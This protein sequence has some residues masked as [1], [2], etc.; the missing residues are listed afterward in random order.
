M[1]KKLGILADIHY[2][3]S[4]SEVLLEDGAYPIVGTGGIYG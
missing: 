1:N 3:K 4:P 2:G